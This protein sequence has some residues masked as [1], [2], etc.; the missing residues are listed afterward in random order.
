VVISGGLEAFTLAK[1]FDIEL[2]CMSENITTTIMNNLETCLDRNGCRGFLIKSRENDNSS[3]LTLS[4]SVVR[5]NELLL[6]NAATQND[7]CCVMNLTVRSYYGR[8]IF[9]LLT[10]HVLLAWESA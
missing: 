10:R 2:P 9:F 7:L 3:S 1:R 6:I 5:G 8:M 4:K